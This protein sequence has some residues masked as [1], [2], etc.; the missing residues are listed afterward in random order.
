MKRQRVL[1]LDSGLT[2]RGGQRQVLLLALGLRNRG[3]EPLLIG[4]PDSPLVKRAQ[5]EGLAVAAIPMV[6]DWDLRAARRIRARIRAWRADVIHAH[7]ARSHA[8]A[9]LAVLGSRT[10]LVVTRRVTFPPKSVGL[11]YGERVNKFIAISNAV[12]DAMIS[13]G[14]ASDRIQVIHSGVALPSPDVIPRDWRSE[15][16]WPRESVIAGVVGAMTAEKGVDSLEAIAAAM[17]A[18]TRGTTRFLLLGG[19]RRGPAEI[20]GVQSHF[21]GFVE[22]IEPATAGIDILLHPSRTEGLG[23]SVIDAM[24]LGVPPV[25]FTVG[26]LPEVVENNASGLLVPAG[27]IRAFADAARRLI[28][29]VALLGKLGHSAMAR[30]REFGSDRMTEQTEMVYQGVIS[31]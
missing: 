6:A 27:D 5:A 8:L 18:E 3:H 16:G 13:R 21:A 20:G 29:D 31:G 9:L 15:L 17:P 4:A 26:G 12:R 2:W 25:A 11:K 30:S 19:S 22:A 28:E 7:D 14:I 1:H 23:T 10:P 24:A